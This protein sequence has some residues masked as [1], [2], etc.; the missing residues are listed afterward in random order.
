MNPHPSHSQLPTEKEVSS[1]PKEKHSLRPS[2][3]EIYQRHADMVYNLCLNYLQRAQDAEDVT[4]NTFIK[5]HHVLPSFKGKSSLKTWIYRIAV[6]Q[7]LD[8]IKASK[9]QKRS[10]IMISI[11]GD[12]EQDR[13][14]YL[15]DFNHPG[16]KMEDEESVQKIMYHINQLPHKQ[17]TALLLKSVEDLSIREIAEVMKCSPKAVESLLSRARSKLKKSL[18]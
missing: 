2:F 5:I 11:H 17:K 14:F 12:E 15:P 10:G 13:S 4:Q 3:E 18:K 9:R 6:N 7:C 16:V 8:F 1:G